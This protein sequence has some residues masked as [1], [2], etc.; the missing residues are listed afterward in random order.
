VA[1]IATVILVLVTLFGAVPV[2][3]QV[4]RRSFAGQGSIAMLEN[5]LGGW[6]GKALVLAIEEGIRRSSRFLSVSLPRRFPLI[7]Q[8]SLVQIQPPQ[9]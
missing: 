2:Y 3:V 1:P 5:L 8:R 7:T 4:A 6:T 9:P